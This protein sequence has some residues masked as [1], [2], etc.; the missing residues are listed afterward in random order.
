M[1]FISMMDVIILLITWLVI[2]K[3]GL[4][5]GC[6]EELREITATQQ[7]IVYENSKLVAVV[8]T[9]ESLKSC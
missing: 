6:I 7:S 3:A 9:T 4:P 5:T 1:K 8:E 2:V